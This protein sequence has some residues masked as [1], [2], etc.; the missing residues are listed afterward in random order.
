M[1]A[2]TFQ[3]RLIPGRSISRRAPANG[4][5]RTLDEPRLYYIENS[6]TGIQA[7]DPYGFVL[8]AEFVM[9]RVPLILTLDAHRVPFGSMFFLHIISEDGIGNQEIRQLYLGEQ[10]TVDFALSHA[11]L[12]PM[13]GKRVTF[14]YEV[15]WPD[16][17]RY[18]GPGIAFHIVEPMKIGGF[19]LEGVPPGEPINP[20]D[21]PDGITA[22]IDRIPNLPPY[23]EPALNWW[24]NGALNGFLDTLLTLPFDLKGLG[25]HDVEIRL[26][27]LAYSGFYEAGYT[28]VFGTPIL[29]LI[30]FPWPNRPFPLFTNLGRRYIAGPGK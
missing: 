6:R 15:A 29:E 18:P 5:G 28:D 8:P 13:L 24:V 10:Q 21:H 12:E 7:A 23:A 4:P 17:T 19:H 9:E 16:G 22:R 2:H 1:T 30:V 25:D 14:Q 3:S 26:P 11:W 20:A 27:P